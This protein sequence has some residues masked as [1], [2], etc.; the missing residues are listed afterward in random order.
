MCQFT[1]PPNSTSKAVKHKTVED[2]WYFIGSSGQVWRKHSD[3]E[4]V[5]E[6][7]PDVFRC[8]GGDGGSQRNIFIHLLKLYF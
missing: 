2:I 6:V 5:T 4:E 8:R 1:L 7:I 3:I